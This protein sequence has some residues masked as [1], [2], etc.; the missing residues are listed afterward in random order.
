MKKLLIGDSD[1]V[2]AIPQAESEKLQLC[3][4]IQVFA[5]YQISQLVL[6]FVFGVISTASKLFCN[7]QKLRFQQRC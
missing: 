6:A 7:F 5:E 3:G 4:I 1:F 2:I